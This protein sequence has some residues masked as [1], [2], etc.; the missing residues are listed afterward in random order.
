MGDNT[1]NLKT[2]IWEFLKLFIPLALVLVAFVGFLANGKAK[3]ENERLKADERNL[4][5]V[6]KHVCE[7]DLAAHVADAAFLASAV[8]LLL[9]KG[10]STD[11]ANLKIANIFYDFAK[12]CNVYSQLRILDEFGI[13]RLRVNCQPGSITFASTKELQTKTHSE[14][15]L[16]GL[17]IEPG[18]VY[19]SPIELNR[20]SGRLEV[21]FN[22]TLRLASPITDPQ[23]RTTGLVVLNFK[24][25]ALFDR[26]RQAAGYSSGQIL[27]VNNEGYWLIGPDP[28]LEWGHSIPERMA[29]NFSAIHPR[30]WS[31]IQK[32][33]QG[34]FITDG[35]LFTFASLRIQNRPKSYVVIRT[36]ASGAPIIISLVPESE[37]A[38]PW[39]GQVV[40]GTVFSLL[41]LAIVCW[42]W[43]QSRV[44]RQ[45]IEENLRNRDNMLTA[46][47]L[48]TRDAIV[49]IDCHDKILFWSK[50][51][52]DMFGYTEEEARQG[53][54]HEL[55]APEQYHEAIAKGMDRFAQT[56]RGVVFGGRSEFTVK[57]KDGSEL[58]VEV[59][60][61]PLLDGGHWRAVG[62]LR[63]ITKR[64]LAEKRLR[65]MATTDA[66]TGLANRRFFTELA[67]AEINRTN[68]YGGPVSMIMFDVD[69]FKKVNDTFGHDVGDEVLKA[70]CQTAAKNIRDV[71]LLGRIGG[72]EFAVLLPETGSGA[73]A[74]V[75]ERLRAAVEKA[76]AHTTAGEIGFTISLGVTTC[77]G[78]QAD[79]AKMLKTAD[80]A[81]YQAKNDGRN[82]VRVA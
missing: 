30:A 11:L 80:D 81:M 69:R 18:A 9:P 44:T 76:T 70:L 17:S 33:S 42:F 77:G 40:F 22:P 25:S 82:L 38:A 23:G 67:Q 57:R 79:L 12:R 10:D 50:A 19:V 56:G 74:E 46:V 35:G 8:S 62:G 60:V 3:G 28:S 68:R 58:S 27:L 75:A 64:K 37:L 73:A 34:Q 2:R 48:S 71:D 63:D 65:E 41:V 32:Q 72:E 43:A 13:E 6:E 31:R 24:G 49:E 29:H 14:Y 15:F 78:E 45:T 55:I 36:G 1:K 5:Q 51:A 54:F 7:T 61:V 53:R 26:M 47:S 20:E 66:L 21:P 39:T 59:E 52:E 16:H 4:V